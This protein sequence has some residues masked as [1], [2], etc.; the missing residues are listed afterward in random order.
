VNKVT[1]AHQTDRQIC[2]SL[3]NRVELRADRI[4]FAIADLEI[5]LIRDVVKQVDAESREVAIG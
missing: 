4:N 1:V 2:L 5:G 3:A